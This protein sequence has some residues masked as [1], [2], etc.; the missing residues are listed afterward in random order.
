M[1]HKDRHGEL[2]AECN[3]CGCEEAGGVTDDFRAFVDELKA[4]GWLIRKED[5]EWQHI[6]PDC[7]R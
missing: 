5:D 2:L 1:I 4:M 6:C 7:R 3:E